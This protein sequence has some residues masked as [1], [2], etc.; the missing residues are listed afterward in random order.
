MSCINPLIAYPSGF[1]E[2][3]KMKY[4]PMK[5]RD[6][7]T[8][9][10]L[11]SKAYL[12][13]KKQL[14]KDCD[15][16]YPPIEIPCGKCIGCRLDHSRQWALRCMMELKEH[17][18]ACFVTLTYSESHVPI[19]FMPDPDTG[20][21]IAVYTLKKRDLQ[22][23]WKRLRKYLGDDCKIRYFACGEYGSQ[24]FRPHYHAI[25]FGFM[26]DDLRLYQKND[27]SNYY[28]SE[29]LNKIWDNGQVIVANVNFDTCAYVARYTAKKTV[30]TIGDEFYKSHNLEVPFLVMSRRPGIGWNYMSDNPGLFRSDRIYIAG[31]DPVDGPLPRSFYKKLE[32]V[33][34][35]LYEELHEKRQNRGDTYERAIMMAHKVPYSKIL[36][37]A[38]ANLLARARAIQRNK[39]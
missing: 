12:E 29:T 20:E 17:E 15:T 4:I 7:N 11:H 38:E 33:D 16:F 19:T 9:D 31:S 18:K 2:N 1:S 22:L 26:P 13:E 39:I 34:H 24:S 36:S 3:G 6:Q 37:D 23:F 28:T 5:R 27:S 14:R 32:N 35:D 21:A 10:W 8:G 25:I 30:G